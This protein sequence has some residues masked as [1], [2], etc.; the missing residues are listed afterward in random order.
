MNGVNDKE[1]KNS[2]YAVIC[3]RSGTGFKISLVGYSEVV[4]KVQ[5]RE[6]RNLA[7]GED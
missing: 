2:V 1:R 6:K 3:G 5:M 4:L 7:E